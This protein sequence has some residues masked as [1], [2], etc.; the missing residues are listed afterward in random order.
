MTGPGVRFVSAALV[1][2]S[3]EAL[4]GCGVSHIGEYTP[5]T[6]TYKQPVE[7]EAAPAA[8]EDGSLF[9]A[10]GQLLNAVADVRALEINDIV[11]VKIVEVAEA[12]RSANTDVAKGRRAVLFARNG[13]GTSSRRRDDT[14]IGFPE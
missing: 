11:V 7:Q 10:Q 5:K 8:D 9:A 14:R 3:A 1:V 4:I 6:R 12:E 13:R 2:V